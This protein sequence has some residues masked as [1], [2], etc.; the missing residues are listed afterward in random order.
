MTLPSDL[1]SRLIPWPVDSSSQHTVAVEFTV[2]ELSLL[3]KAARET[4]YADESEGEEIKIQGKQ[5]WRRLYEAMEHHKGDHRQYLLE[6]THP[7][8]V[9]AEDYSFFLASLYAYQHCFTVGDGPLR[10][11]IVRRLAAVEL[12]IAVAGA[13]G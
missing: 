2:E 6:A 7:F 5:M 13:S 9:S 11:E 3:A 10:D 12:E 4:R 1:V 8:H